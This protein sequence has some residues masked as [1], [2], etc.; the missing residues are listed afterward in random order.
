[1]E[2]SAIVSVVRDVVLRGAPIAGEEISEILRSNDW[3]SENSV[4]GRIPRN[5]RHNELSLSV[6]PEE[7]EEGPAVV[8]LYL[9]AIPPDWESPEYASAIDGEYV[10]ES[11]RVSYWADG[12]IHDLSAQG[13][14][15]IPVAENP[16]YRI[17]MFDTSCW[18]IGDFYLTAG[19]SHADPEDTPIL[20]MIRV[21]QAGR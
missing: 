6:Y 8:D 9:Q 12:I 17:D 3:A 19:I 1:M 5:W 18:Q 20:L 14:D 13:I 10:S 15:A 11:A 7:E 21:R 16:E 2:N 4:T